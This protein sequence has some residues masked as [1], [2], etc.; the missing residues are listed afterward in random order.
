MIHRVPYFMPQNKPREKFEA[1]GLI[2]HFLRLLSSSTIYI[3]YFFGPF[4]A[5]FL[6]LSL[7]WSIS[8]I[9]K[10]S[11]EFVSSLCQIAIW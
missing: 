3:G 1:K 5:H 4:T 11:L 6:F 9:G 10:V 8:H 7:S 2:I